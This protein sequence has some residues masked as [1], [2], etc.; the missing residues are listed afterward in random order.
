MNKNIDKVNVV[1]VYLVEEEEAV[2]KAHRG[3][4][5]SYIE[6]AGRI[7]YPRGLTWKTIIDGKPRYC[8]D[9]DQDTVLGPAGR[10]M[11]IKSYLSMPIF[12][13]EES[14]GCLNI[15]SLQENAFD[16]EELKLLEIAAQQI[17]VAINNAQRANALR[18]SEERYR[19]IVED[20]TELI[21][22]F[23]PEGTLTFIN[24][25]YCR[26][27]AK[28]REE[29]IGLSFVP[30]IPDED[31]ERCKNHI[32]SLSL[33]N[34]VTTVEHRVFMPSGEVRWHQWTDRAIFDQKG[35]IV[36]FQ[37][38]GR[39]ITERK[40]IEEVLREKESRLE[41]QQKA[42]LELAKINTLSDG[43]LKT[44]LQKITESSSRTLGVERVSVWLYKDNRSK[45]VSF[46]MYEQ[47]L[48]RHSEGIEL[49]VD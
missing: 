47:S 38:V 7:P 36:E 8:A 25:S 11:G 16:E 32:A 39:D 48:G 4:T 35:N 12:F 43:D 46:D 22:R 20:Q 9:A 41:K 2:L 19:A 5:T 33:E 23:L 42:L 1:S 10:E 29:L 27:F 6:R 26:Y 28:K 37:A 44:A 45:I 34:P 15:S 14:V 18:Q 31:Q 17:E 13:E 24:D 30:L 21:C 40:R 3:F 49:S